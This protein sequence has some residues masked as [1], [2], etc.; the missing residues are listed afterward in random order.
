MIRRPPRSTL[1]PY[2]TLF[3]SMFG[4]LI[5]PAVRGLDLS[6]RPWENSYN[7]PVG[8]DDPV[9]DH[10]YEFQE[11]ADGGPE[12]NMTSLER[13]GG[14]GLATTTSHAMILNEYGWLWLNRDGS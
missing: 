3:R 6:N 14:I 9:E 5:I 11:M 12:F 4:E 7:S 13:P 8:A 2:T 1:F 10:P